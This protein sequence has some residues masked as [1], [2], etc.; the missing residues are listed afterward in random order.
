MILSIVQYFIMKMLIKLSMVGINSLLRLGPN[1][2]T[3]IGW[4]NRKET[5]TILCIPLVPFSCYLL[6]GNY[7]GK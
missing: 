5:V 2:L 3:K 4:E 1:T 7:G 6:N